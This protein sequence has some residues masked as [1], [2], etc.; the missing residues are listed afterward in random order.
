MGTAVQALRNLPWFGTHGRKLGLAEGK[1]PP[2]TAALEA[3]SPWGG[4]WSGGRGLGKRCSG[5]QPQAAQD[6]VV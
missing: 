3:L 1:S 4:K 2:S 6:M 5:R